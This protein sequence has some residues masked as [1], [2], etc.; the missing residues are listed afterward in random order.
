MDIPPLPPTPPPIY[1]CVILVLDNYDSFTYNLVHLVARSA[2]VRV[3]RNDA[4][5]VEEVRTLRPDGLLISPGPGRPADA[6]ITEAVIRELGA[7]IPILGVCLGHQAIGEVFGG[8]VTYAPTLMHGKTSAI[9]HDGTGLFEDVAP[10]FT[11]TRYHSL[12]VDRATLPDVLAVT[13]ETEDGVIMGLRHRTWPVEGIQFHP[14]SV[15]TSEGPKLID[16]W[17]RRVRSAKLNPNP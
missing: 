10:G 11:A 12:V 3:V 9:L 8:T 4:L 2:A 5:T 15:L 14:E 1:T 16:N 6:G 13:A 7:D 17:L